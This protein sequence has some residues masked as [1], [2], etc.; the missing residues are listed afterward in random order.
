MSGE[1]RCWR[2]R[3]RRSRGQEEEGKVEFEMTRRGAKQRPQLTATKGK[4]SEGKG[5]GVK[6]MKG[7]GRE[8]T[9]AGAQREW[10][11]QTR[12]RR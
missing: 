8:G 1:E 11:S 10:K 4:R 5:R 3:K 12:K 9:R 6:G 2:K 7:R